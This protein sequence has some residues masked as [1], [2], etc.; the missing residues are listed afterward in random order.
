MRAIEAVIFDYG[1]VLSTTP[2]VGIAEFDGPDGLPREVAGPAAVRDGGRPRRGRPR[3][4]P[5]TTGTCSRPAASPSTS[6]TTG[7]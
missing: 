7:W 2:F 5:T 6:S 4:S 3:T 1:G